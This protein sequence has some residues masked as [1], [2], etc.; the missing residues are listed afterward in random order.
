MKFVGQMSWAP[1]FK[2]S[3]EHVAIYLH[4]TKLYSLSSQSKF[5]TTFVV[6]R[7]TPVFIGEVLLM[8][9]EF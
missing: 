6:K 3:Q 1:D 8:K 2:I 7:M 4:I 5:S 9:E